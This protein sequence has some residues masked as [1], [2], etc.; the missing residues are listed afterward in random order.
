M[1][2]FKKTD[3]K[4]SQKK[5]KLDDST[6]VKV[7][8]LSNFESSNYIV[9]HPDDNFVQKIDIKKEEDI[10][11]IFDKC[12]DFF[13]RINFF[14]ITNDKSVTG[15]PYSYLIGAKHALIYFDQQLLGL[16]ERFRIRANFYYL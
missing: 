11:L 3:P 2:K 15:L 4:I 9:E 7:E 1:K 12:T 10:H 5:M 8:N 6:N 16:R 13:K 14:D